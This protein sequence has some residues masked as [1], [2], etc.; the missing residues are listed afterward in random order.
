MP[1]LPSLIIGRLYEGNTWKLF[2]EILSILTVHAPDA[3]CYIRRDL[4]FWDTAV[5]ILKEEYIEF[6]PYS[7]LVSTTGTVN[8]AAKNRRR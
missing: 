3:A 7:S 8:K 2:L 5:G 1:W 4:W 6:Q